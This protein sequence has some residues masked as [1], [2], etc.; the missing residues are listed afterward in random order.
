MQTEIPIVNRHEA[1]M[2][3]RP[4]SPTPRPKPWGQGKVTDGVIEI[5]CRGW[6]SFESFIHE[7]MIDLPDYVWRGHRCSDWPLLSSLDRRLQRAKDPADPRI[8]ESLLRRFKLSARGRRAVETLPKN[9]DEWWALGQHFG[10]ATP[11]LD[12]TASPF[13]AAHFAF[14]DTGQPQTPFRTVF[15]M[16]ARLVHQKSQ[17]LAKATGEKKQDIRFVCPLVD[18]NPRLLHQRGLFTKLPAG[19]DVESWVRTHFAGR[20]D[21]W[22]LIKIM[23]PDTSREMFLRSL[24][25]MAISPLEL[26]PDLTG[27]GLYC[28]LGLDIDNYCQNLAATD[29]F[30]PA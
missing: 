26:F 11:L 6:P 9:D 12:W 25:R 5:T 20:K 7:T 10:L 27:A 19:Q 14:A 1:P 15:G 18:D 21:K 24:E 8:P 16:S 29:I 17:A 3:K 23:I 22:I 13:V 28:N 30:D 4:A 2:P